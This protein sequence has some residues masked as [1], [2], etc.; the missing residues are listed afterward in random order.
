MCRRE[1]QVRATGQIAPERGRSATATRGTIDLTVEELEDK[2]RGGVLGQLLG[3][4]NGLPHEGMYI[5]EPGPIERYVPSLLDGAWADDDTDIEW[6]YITAMD[7]LKKTY[8]SPGEITELWVKHINRKI[9]R[10]NL[11]VRQLMDIGIAP[12]LTGRIALNPWAEINVSGHFVAEIFG[13]LA[14]ALPCTASRIGLNYTH[15][16]VDGEPAQSTQLFVSMI[17]VAFVEKNF[18]RILEE[19]LA[20]VDPASE[21]HRIVEQVRRIW[22][23]HPHD[24]K[25]CRQR[26]KELYQSCAK[27]DWADTRLNTA[28]MVGA[29]LYGKGDFVETLRLSF[30]FGWDTD[31][32]AATLGTIVGV[33]TGRRWMDSQGWAIKDVYRNR[34][35]IW[36]VYGARAPQWSEEVVRDHMPDDETITSYT[37]KVIAVA[38]RVLAE[39]GAQIVTRDGKQIYR[40]S[41]EA[42]TNV[43]PLP[44]PL[45]RVHELRR[46]LVPQIEQWLSG[47]DQERA[48]AAYVAFCLE[49]SQRFERERPDD[50]RR[51]I[52]AL[53]QC[54]ALLLQLWYAFDSPVRERVMVALYKNRPA[55]AQ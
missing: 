2:I 38:K 55:N 35:R 12:P 24:W 26:I 39:Q 4:L 6:V 40:I 42:S 21:V 10:S 19:G 54:Q 47:T 22:Q 18:E 45:N 46:E 53:E 25:M 51:A 5:Q 36:D 32:N 37:N 15:V 17:A 11:Y 23:E 44:H 48:R 28:A 13:L 34:F 16:S 52:G 50:W 27:C 31:C 9:W 3:N 33:M 41:A 20:A 30:N 7:R 29:F 8:L 49:E 14:P 43:E 1:E